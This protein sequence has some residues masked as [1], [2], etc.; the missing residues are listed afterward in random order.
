MHLCSPGQRQ[1]T[2]AYLTEDLNLLESPQVRGKAARGEYYNRLYLIGAD[3]LMLPEPYYVEHRA[4]NEPIVS[5]VETNEDITDVDTLRSTAQ[6]QVDTAATVSR[7]YTC[8]VADLEKLLPQEYGHL[9]LEV[10]DT[11]I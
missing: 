3:G 2:G 5:H 10:Y 6:A 8:K 9:R 4:E 7:S 1:P 11:V